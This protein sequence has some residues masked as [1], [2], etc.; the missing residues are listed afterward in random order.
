MGNKLSGW[1][2][3]ELQSMAWMSLWKLVVSGVPQG[4]AL[5]PVLFCMFISGIGS[6]IE[7]TLSKFADDTKLH[8]A[9]NMPEGQDAI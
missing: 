8:G 1:P 7:C 6:R 5:E 3:P 4:P 9:V 2:R